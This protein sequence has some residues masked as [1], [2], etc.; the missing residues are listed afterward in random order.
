MTLLKMPTD[1][2]LMLLL[3]L[4]LVLRTASAIGSSLD[5]ADSLATA[6]Q[7]LATYRKSLDTAHSYS[8]FRQ[9]TLTEAFNSR[10]HYAFAKGPLALVLQLE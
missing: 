10:V 8:L 9:I 3:M 5:A 4:I 6:F 7:S 2:L 1:E